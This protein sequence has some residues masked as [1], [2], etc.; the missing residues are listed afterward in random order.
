MQMAATTPV[1][2]RRDGPSRNNQAH[3]KE[4]SSFGQK[5]FCRVLGTLFF[6][7]DP[8]DRN[9]THWKLMGAAST[10]IGKG[11]NAPILLEGRRYP[12]RDRVMVLLSIRAGLQEIAMVRW[13]MVMRRAM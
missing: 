13:S 11:H 10:A 1:R 6:D 12:L 9:E 8:R 4:K 7:C 5:L 2:N 3:L